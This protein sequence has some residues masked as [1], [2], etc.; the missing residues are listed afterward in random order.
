MPDR[1]R[2]ALALAAVALWSGAAQARKP[3]DAGALVRAITA[4]D[5]AATQAALAA[6]A[7][8]NAP[9]DYSATPLALAVNTQD[10]AL[11]AALLAAHAKPNTADADGVTPLALACELGNAAIVSHLLDAHADVRAAAPDGTRPLAICARFGPADAVARM[12]A[13]GAAPDTPDARGQTPLM[14]AASVGRTEAIAA[15]LKAGADANRI[16]KGDFTPL[17]FAIKSGIPAATAAL[18]AAGAKADYR[19]PENT[20]ALQLALYQHSYG[21][22]ALL[23]PYGFDLAARDREGKTPLDAAAEGGD[24]TLV[25]LLLAR[26]ADANALSGPS[27]IKWVTEANF[28]QP[29]PPV[30]PTPPLLW[31]AQSGH[32]EAMAAL[33]AGGADP[34]FVAADGT[35]VVLAAA[36]GGSDAALRLALQVAPNVDV[37]NANGFTALHI[38]VGG[39][40]FPELAAMLRTLAAHSARTDLKSKYGTAA[41]IA[42][43]GLNEVKAIF[44]ETFPDGAGAKP[45]NRG[46]QQLAARP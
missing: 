7:D 4:D 38:L 17:F 14:W 39:R 32:A 11:V 35:N 19:G 41:E 44:V 18:L 3:V 1:A 45:V 30:P 20:S 46:G 8:P 31:A 27:T 42:A 2:I 5:L 26:G 22:A 15:L 34:H 9:L 36:K 16:S 37:A 33:L 21:A 10:P 6:Q 24:A 23:V 25:K 43:K 28:G 29:P 13:A 12:L 40:P